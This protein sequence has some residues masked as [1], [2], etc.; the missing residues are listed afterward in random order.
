M[1]KFATLAAAIAIGLAAAGTA[2][3]QD[4]ATPKS[5][6]D[7]IAELDA[8][9]S[10]GELDALVGEDSG[11]FFLSRRVAPSRLSRDEVRA[12]VQTA[13][14]RGEL[15]GMYGEDSGS[16]LL[17]RAYWATM[18]RHAARDNGQAGSAAMLAR[19]PR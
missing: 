12:A 3:A 10:S 6:A 4:V 19:S 18:T 15:T 2:H 8:A 14:A 1:S 5:R 9:R 13:N 16:A 7:A 11:S 17:N